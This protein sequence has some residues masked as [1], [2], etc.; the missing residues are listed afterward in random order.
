MEDE[1]VPKCQTAKRAVPIYLEIT[2]NVLELVPL[3]FPTGRQI[4]HMGAILCKYRNRDNAQASPF[5]GGA[6]LYQ[7]KIDFSIKCCLNTFHLYT[8]FSNYV[9]F[10]TITFLVFGLEKFTIVLLRVR[11]WEVVSIIPFSLAGSA[12]GQE[13]SY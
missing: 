10:T 12:I 1:H 4:F 3:C 8:I 7:Q 2:V 5:S 9:T 13:R 6:I 11:G